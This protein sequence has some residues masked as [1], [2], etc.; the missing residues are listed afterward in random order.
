MPR[1]NRCL[2]MT[3]V[4]FMSVVEILP[5]SVGMFIVW[6]PLLNIVGFSIGVLNYVVFLCKGCDVCCVF[7]CIVRRGAVSDR[8]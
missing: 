7:V 8:V 4:C 6:Q 1:D 3:H 5:V 2:Y